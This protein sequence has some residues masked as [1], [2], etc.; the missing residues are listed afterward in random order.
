MAKQPFLARLVIIRC[1][2]QGAV[3]AQSLRGASGLYGFARRIG[4]R[5]GKDETTFVGVLNRE[6]NYFLTF[7]M[8]ECRRFTSRAD[9]DDAVDSGRNL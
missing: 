7:I 6:A 3:R 1:D 9:G 8:G 2:Q 5:P 4:S